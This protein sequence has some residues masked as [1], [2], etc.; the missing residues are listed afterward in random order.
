MNIL[1]LGIN[2]D[3][4]KSILEKIYSKENN[5]FLTFSKKKP[6]LKKKNL[7]YIRIDF[8]KKNSVRKKIKLLNKFNF[9]IVINNVGDSNPYKNFTSL[10]DEDIYQSFN[11]NFFSPFKIIFSILKRNIKLKKKLNIINISSNT[12]KYFGSD[13][14]FPYFISKSTLETSLKFISNKFSKN[15]IRTNIIRPGLIKVEKTTKLLGYSKK[16]FKK[17]QTLIPTGRAGRPEDISNLVKFLS[18]ENSEYI[19]GQVISVSGGE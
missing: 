10:S 7:K 19:Y 3:I 9:N 16:N 17:R 4:G 11:I 13:K 1:L 2:G 15:K 6:D 14:N 12:I 18:D 5:Y 8:S